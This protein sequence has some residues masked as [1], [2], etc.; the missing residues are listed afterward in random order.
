MRLLLVRHASAVPRGTPGIS[1]D[2]RPLTPRGE[3]R[4]RQAARGL[5]SALSR[6]DAVLT[7]PLP[8]AAATADL[9]AE[10][11]GRLEP[12]P[13]PALVG[14]TLDEVQVAL[15]GFEAG[16]TVALVGHE[17]D[18]SEWLGALLGC[19]RGEGLAF[20]KGGA[21]LVEVPGTLAEGGSL[22]AFLPPRVLRRLASGLAD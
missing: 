6:P 12:R 2:E 3:R 4:F 19:P 17:P 9:L 8:R 13:E 15:R 21:A 14:G 10:A 11:W 22:L 7:S 18:L 1:D 5:A 20:R 16:A